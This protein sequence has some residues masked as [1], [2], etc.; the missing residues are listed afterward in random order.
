MARAVSPDVRFVD[1]E[2]TFD[3]ASRTASA[4]ATVSFVVE[5]AAGRPALDLRQRVEWLR[6]DDKPLGVDAFFH[7]DLGGGPGADMRVLDV[8]IAAGAEHR[9]ELG[10]HLDKPDAQGAEAV[11]WS[12]DGIRFDLWMSDLYPGRYLEMWVPSPLCH[13][14]FALRMEVTV[15]GTERPHVLVANSSSV[16]TGPWHNRWLVRYPANFCSLSPMLVL[17]PADEVELVHSRVVLA[18]RNAPV[19]IV[20]AR[21]REVDADVQAVSADVGGWLAY[22]A[23]RYGRWVHGDT[24]SAFVWG[25]GRGMEYDGATTA[26]T[27]AMEHEVFHTWFGRG[28]KPARASDGWIDE[29]WTSWATASRRVEGPRFA[30]EELG[31][32]QDPVLLCPPHPWSRR[33]PAESYRS[34]ERLFAGVAH[35]LG[36]AERLR[37][38]MASWYQAHAGDLVSTEGLER[39]LSEWSGKD[40]GPLWERYVYGGVPPATR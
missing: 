1:A 31:L 27:A 35:L 4:R 25:P 8:E 12:D 24:F 36:G 30:S 39:H 18:G 10:Y 23:A 29:A 16:Q 37:S 15:T 20:A 22:L 17:A 19:E 26:S 40:L 9:L 33:T 11:G 32:D 34:G 5:G 28:V 3:V 14:R 6:L 2:V 38:A 13:D 21:H 7:R